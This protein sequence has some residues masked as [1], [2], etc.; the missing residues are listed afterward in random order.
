M[1]RLLTLAVALA[2]GA[3]LAAEA[4]ALQSGSNSGR[5]VNQIIVYGSDPCPPSRGDDIVVCARRPEDDRYRIP[6]PFRGN[7]DLRDNQSWAAN[8]R[9]LEYVGRTGINSCSTVGPGGF[10]GCWEK[11]MR[12]AREE[13]AAEAEDE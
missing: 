6:E 5:R 13:R 9:S 3:G 12:A 10:T 1:K 4:S 11:M 7:T 8:A 2:A